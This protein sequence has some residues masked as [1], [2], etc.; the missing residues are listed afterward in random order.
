MIKK[1]R[2]Q[3]VCWTEEG[4]R[5]LETLK[6]LVNQCAKLFFEKDGY[7][8]YLQTDASDYGIGAYMFYKIDGIDYPIQFLSKSLSKA[9]R[10]WAIPDKEAYAT[11]YVILHWE[12]LL[13]GVRFVLQTDHRNLT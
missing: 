4:R 9:Q 13:H 11:Y 8:I 1:Q 5:A 3:S 6:S 12:F 2:I 10:K 7:P